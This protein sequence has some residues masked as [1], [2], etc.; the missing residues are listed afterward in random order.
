MSQIFAL[1][2]VVE[3]AVP[4]WVTGFYLLVLAG[5]VLCLAIEEKIHAKKSL[6]FICGG[7]CGIRIISSFLKIL[8]HCQKALM[9]ILTSFDPR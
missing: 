8:I 2:D 3:H 9:N 6:I 4:G 7:I 5:M 1:S